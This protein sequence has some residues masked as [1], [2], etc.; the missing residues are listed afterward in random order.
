MDS[1]PS[2]MPGMDAAFGQPPL[3]ILADPW[4]LPLAA[5]PGLVDVWSQDPQAGGASTPPRP[6]PTLAGIFD[7]PS[8][9]VPGASPWA[10]DHPGPVGP[11][12]PA[13]DAIDP[14]AIAPAGVPDPGPALG[15]GLAGGHALPDVDALIQQHMA[16]QQAAEPEAAEPGA[17]VASWPAMHMHGVPAADDSGLL[18][19][20]A[21]DAS[22]EGMPGQLARAHG[23]Q[24]VEATA[25]SWP[26][27]PDGP[28]AGETHRESPVDPHAGP[29][30]HHLAMPGRQA[31]PAPGHSRDNGPAHGDAAAA[32]PATLAIGARQDGPS[33]SRRPAGAPARGMS[34]SKADDPQGPPAAG[35]G[36]DTAPG[37]LA[38]H[39][40]EA[41]PTPPLEAPPPPGPP[42]PLP[43]R[44]SEPV[45]SPLVAAA[46]IHNDARRLED[47]LQSNIASLARVLA[48]E[49]EV[50]PDDTGDFVPQ[51]EPL[52]PGTDPFALG[53][54]SSALALQLQ[55]SQQHPHSQSHHHSSGGSR[56]ASTHGGAAGAA[57][58]GANLRDSLH[59]PCAAGGRLAA[60]PVEAPCDLDRLA[61]VTAHW[62]LNRPPKP[63]SSWRAFLQQWT[64]PEAGADASLA[65]GGPATSRVVPL[66]VRGDTGSRP[67]ETAAELRALR[68]DPVLRALTQRLVSIDFPDGAAFGATALMKAAALGYSDVLAFL[69]ATGADANRQDQRGWTP[70][71]YSV[72]SGSVV[73]V[74]LLLEAGSDASLQRWP[75]GRQTE[76]ARA[77]QETIKGVPLLRDLLE[78][79]K[80]WLTA[81][82]VAAHPYFGYPAIL[83]V[84]DEYEDRRRRQLAEW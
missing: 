81:R 1:P 77:L 31:A 50:A 15:I 54:A 52:H 39:P 57:G 74:Q 49:E 22:S 60:A 30:D 34:P 20:A 47:Q 10:T 5:G 83:S 68:E 53:F 13:L 48:E 42:T 64:R 29:A 66:R 56:R 26:G 63:G 37:L 19:E 38:R 58:T 67:A 75:P 3:S 36:I 9:L 76:S 23:P 6:D 80:P 27:A 11:L 24:P 40:A 61:E 17:P 14:W 72:W 16:R 70:L 59:A 18:T 82:D 41:P 44:V 46:L 45:A 21:P 51:I 12:G 62:P 32:A 55:G 25:T 69:I 4:A 2:S 71:I 8:G 33:G 79:G 43:S 73:S 65:A 28:S 84:L 78:P 35:L 7:S